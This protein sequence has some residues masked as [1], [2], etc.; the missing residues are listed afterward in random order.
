MGQASP[1]EGQGLEEVDV[2]PGQF[3]L[4]EHSLM[5]TSSCKGDCTRKDSMNHRKKERMNMAK[6]VVV[7][8]QVV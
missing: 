3:H 8:T 1:L 4:P 6:Q 2:L 5:V 7:L